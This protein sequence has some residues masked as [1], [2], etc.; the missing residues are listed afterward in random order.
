MLTTVDL[1]PRPTP[2]GAYRY[3][4]PINIGGGGHA[5]EVAVML[6]TG[7]S[8]LM[9][10]DVS[11]G[12]C[13]E[14]DPAV[15]GSCYNS[16]ASV[17]S[18]ANPSGGAGFSIAIDG[19]QIDGSF[20]SSLDELALPG[21][22]RPG[23][24]PTVTVAQLGAVSTNGIGPRDVLPYFWAD[25]AGVLGLSPQP[26]AVLAHPWDAYLSSFGS[27]FTLDLNP[28]GR[29]RLGLGA[30]NRSW[31]VGALQWSAAQNA[32]A[33]HRL[34]L[35]ELAVCGAGLIGQTSVFWPALVDTGASCLGLPEPLFEALF[36][37]VSVA[38]CSTPRTPT[39]KCR[40]PA[41]VPAAS[42]P[43][44]S[45]RLTQNAP[46][47]QLP[48][49]ELLLPADPVDGARE[50]CVLPL[51]APGGETPPWSSP[52]PQPIIL[53]THA[54]QP[55]VAAFEM[56]ATRRRVGLAAKAVPAP[57]A[58]RAARRAASCAV[59]AECRGQQ[60]FEASRNRC[61]QPECQ[62]FFSSLDAEAGVC[63]YSASFRVVIAMVIGA[64][65]LVEMVLH[66][67]QH[68]LPLLSSA[69]GPDGF[70]WRLLSGWLAPAHG[71]SAAAAPHDEG[72][73][74]R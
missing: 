56:S 54:L 57:A 30:P 65:G 36:A 41:S 26:R 32:P 16:S 68:R 66:E 72:A 17:T 18:V 38:N 35:F 70:W 52:W 49:E 48:L 15:Y 67:A 7:S 19:L 21:V 23:G 53:G 5:Q 20:T 40:V 61:V 51:P 9:V 43:V 28:T 44:L 58:E 64:F 6:D 3:L 37:W 14:D 22:A 42:L 24:S 2:D 29:S 62:A 74:A 13:H 59:R 73:A 25:A 33:F 55:F 39:S 10:S 71:P 50:L 47:L 1:I 60:R 11:R 12:A 46:Q 34:E 63:R 27:A 45:F 8:Y 4:L 69:A 31:A